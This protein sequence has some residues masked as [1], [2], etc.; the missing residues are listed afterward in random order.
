MVK[1]RRVTGGRARPVSRVV[2]WWVAGS[3]TPLYARHK[4]TRLLP[5]GEEGAGWDHVEGVGG[6]LVHDA[7]RIREWP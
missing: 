6:R 2:D 3:R 4:L 7:T 1:W 5:K